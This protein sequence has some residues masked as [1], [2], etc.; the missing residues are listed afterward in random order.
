[1]RNSWS[2]VIP[3]TP[4]HQSKLGQRAG[5]EGSG[6]GL[7]PG[8]LWCRNKDASARNALVQGPEGGV[9]ERG[10]ARDVKRQEKKGKDAR[11]QGW[12]GNE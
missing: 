1:M 9:G 3:G 6:A 12:D 7:V 10:S 4:Q 8:E 5:R 11:P 2:L